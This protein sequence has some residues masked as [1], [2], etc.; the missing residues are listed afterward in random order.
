MVQPTVVQPENRRRH[1]DPRRALAAPDVRRSRSIA[2]GTGSRSEI[3]PT[4]GRLNRL[5]GRLSRSQNASAESCSGLLGAGNLDEDS[6][7][8]VEDTLLLADLGAKAAAPRSPRSCA[9]RS[10][11]TGVTDARRAPARCCAGC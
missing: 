3:E 1:R 10:R 7:T 4:A 8:D 6:W 11:R 2:D 9:P 5:R